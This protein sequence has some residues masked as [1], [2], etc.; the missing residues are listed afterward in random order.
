MPGEVL[1]VVTL[2]ETQFTS[3]MTN[4]GAVF[5]IFGDGG[6]GGDA[7]PE[8]NVFDA[9]L[10]VPNL[11][12]DW[13][14]PDP[15]VVE[16]KTGGVWVRVRNSGTVTSCGIYGEGTCNNFPLSLFVKPPAPPRSY[17]FDRFGDCFGYVSPLEPGR[18]TEGKSRSLPGK[19]ICSIAG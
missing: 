19:L 10:G 17:P 15:A 7:N 9:H 11:V 12:I 14:H 8:D 18:S 3:E 5:E 2:I 6:S 13:I 4:L 1:F 16:G